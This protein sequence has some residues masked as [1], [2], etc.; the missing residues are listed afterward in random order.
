VNRQRERES[1]DCNQQRSSSR[2]SSW[3]GARI[4]HGIG[5]Q[6]QACRLSDRRKGRRGEDD[7]HGHT[8][9]MVRKHC[10]HYLLRESRLAKGEIPQRSASKSTRSE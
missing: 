5:N 3:G 7:R 2:A 6:T 9:G 1:R 8:G 4:E 10:L